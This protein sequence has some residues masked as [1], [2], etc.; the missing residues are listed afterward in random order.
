VVA[1]AN[2][3]RWLLGFPLLNNI[4]QKSL[5]LHRLKADILMTSILANLSRLLPVLA[6]T[7]C[8][9]F[10]SADELTTTTGKT[11]TVD[12]IE[13]AVA[14][15]TFNGIKLYGRMKFVNAFPDI[16]IQ[17]VEHFPDIRVLFVSSFPDK[18]GRWQVVE[19][20]ADFTVQLVE[21]FPDIKVKVVEHFPGV[22]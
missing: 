14:E 8:V 5:N 6:L 18:C 11:E 9:H 19:N 13:A 2:L 12:S 7:F 15:C 1:V 20:F 17:Y 21:H 22:D 16:R 10:L 4:M 3:L